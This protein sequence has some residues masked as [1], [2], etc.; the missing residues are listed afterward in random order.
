MPRKGQ[1]CC[2]KT[3][4]TEQDRQ[5]LAGALTESPSVGTWATAD[6]AATSHRLVD[7]PRQPLR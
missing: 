6:T 5:G 4:V 2:R 1:A 3:G 7:S